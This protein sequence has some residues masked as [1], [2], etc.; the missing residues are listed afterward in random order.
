MTSNPL[1][2]II[3]P[4]YNGANYVGEAIQSA[5]AQTYPNIEVLV[6]DDGST[7]GGA[8]RAVIDS[9]GDRIRSISQPN[10]GVA[11]ALNTGITH[12]RGSFF[13]WLSHDDLYRP[14]KVSRQVE[15]WR[16]FASPCVVI[17][18]FE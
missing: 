15:T 4:V 5:L 14:E 12:M 7:D 6:V 17:G 9:F 1:V 18:D 10:G 8:T 16:N 3:V 13:S 11:S 2:S